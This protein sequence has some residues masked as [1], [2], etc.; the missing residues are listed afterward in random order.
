MKSKLL[1]GA[2]TSVFTL[3]IAASA[4]GQC[5]KIK[6][7]S[8]SDSAGN[9]IKVGSDQFGYNYQAHMFNGTYDSSDRILDGKYY[10]TTADYTDDNLIMKW[11]DEWLSNLDCNSD[12]KLDRGGAAGANA[13]LSKGWLT[14]HV[15][16]DYIGG[17]SDSHHYTYFVKIVFDGGA[18]CTASE[19]TC[20]W[21]TFT[22]IEEIYNDP[23]GG[24]H[25]VDR[26][27]L[28]KPAGLGFYTN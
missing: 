21:G 17:D 3:V 23:F 27:R 18:A 5:A 16:G 26:S 19:P 9:V 14:N 2:I 7:G 10:G 1:L 8:I 25:G 4:Y 20:L 22:I 15:E 12:G 6:D 13:N 28:A 11:S 24:Y